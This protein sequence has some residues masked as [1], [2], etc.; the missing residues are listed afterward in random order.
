MS[1]GFILVF[2][3]VWEVNVGGLDVSWGFIDLELW[4]CRG[5]VG[6]DRRGFVEFTFG[7]E[8]SRVLYG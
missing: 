3:G 7:L 1:L 4:F 2:L 6:G 8:S 5:Y